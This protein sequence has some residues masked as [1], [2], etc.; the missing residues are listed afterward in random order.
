MSPGL[1][2]LMTYNKNISRLCCMLWVKEVNSNIYRCLHQVVNRKSWCSWHNLLIY[3]TALVMR[4]EW[5]CKNFSLCLLQWGFCTK[6][7]SLDLSDS[8]S[9]WRLWDELFPWHLS[10]LWSTNTAL[11]RWTLNYYF[12]WEPIMGQTVPGHYLFQP[13]ISSM[14]WKLSL[15]FYG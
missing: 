6:R 10:H 3:M 9:K 11:C 8:P 1:L 4:F 15:L 7:F 2:E 13:S 5:S 14:K 12:I